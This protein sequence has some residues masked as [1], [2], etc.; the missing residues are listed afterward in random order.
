MLDLLWTANVLLEKE[1]ISIGLVF[2]EEVGIIS[3]EFT[4]WGI[5]LKGGGT[6][7]LVIDSFLQ[8]HNISKAH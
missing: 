1:L 8:V 2:D 5:D 4:Q 6:R 7:F 3:R